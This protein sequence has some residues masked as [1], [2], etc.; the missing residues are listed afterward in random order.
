MKETAS[1]S[2]NFENKTKFENDWE[3][4]SW[5]SPASYFLENNHLK[6]TTRPKVVDRVKVRTKR[7]DFTTGVYEWRIF[8]P[9]FKLYDQISIGAFLYHKKRNEFEFDF[10]IGS[11]KKEDREKINLKNDEAI[12]YCVSQFSPSRSSHF[13]VKMGVYSNFK[14]ELIDVNGFYLVKWYINN[15]LVKSLQ[16]EVK[17]NIKFRVHNSLE[18]LHFMG[19][20]KTS[21][22]NYVLFDAFKFTSN[23][24]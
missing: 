1:F 3:D 8:V 18:N 10:E 9:K 12:V 2:E 4:N 11:G 22:E 13:A 5:K 6:I 24:Q 20:N 16:T 17:S 23:Q 15:S 14:M 7:K 19:N 21:T